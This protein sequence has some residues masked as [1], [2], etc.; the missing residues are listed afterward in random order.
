MEGLLSEMHLAV[1]YVA[2][3]IAG[4]KRYEAGDDQ[5]GDCAGAER[6]EAKRGKELGIMLVVPRMLVIHKAHLAWRNLLK[7]EL[8]GWNRWRKGG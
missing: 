8:W 6:S 4:V 7:L 1:G 3:S 2:Y 5:V